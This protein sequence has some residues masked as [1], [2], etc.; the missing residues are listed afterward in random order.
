MANGRRATSAR[1]V[2]AL[3]AVETLCLLG[4]EISRFGMTIWIL[5]HNGEHS[6][7]AFSY[8]MAANVV[9]GML[10]L[11]IAGSVVDRQPRKAVMIGAAIVTAIGTALVFGGALVGELSLPVVLVGA[12]LASIGEAFQWPAL[13][14]TVPLLASAEDLPR[15]N[16][17]LESGRA[18]GHFA[19]PA[20]GGVS[21]A[22]LGVSGLVGIDLFAFVVST[23]VVATLRL[24]S[25][26]AGEE[27]APAGD[28]DEEG[29]HGEAGG[30]EGGDED[31]ESDSLIADAQVGLRWIFAR[32]PV[33]KL[34][35]V[36]TFA[37]FFLAVGE[38]VMQP[39]GLSLVGERELGI[40]NA[41]FGAGMIVGGLLCGPLAKRFTNIN[42]L[43]ASA[44]VLGV[45]YVAYGFARGPVGLAGLNVA[46]AMMI[47]IVN[48][49]LMTIWQLKVPERL[50]GRVFAA[51][52]LIADITTP[53]SFLLAGPISE[54]L[55]PAAYTRLGADAIWGA[56]PAGQ[57]GALCTVLGASLV[58]GFALAWTVRDI[59][60]IE[61]P[62][63][64]SSKP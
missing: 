28:N 10:V 22:V 48:S 55:L 32:R 49:S 45:A 18:I 6:V 23:I 36:A 2:W 19:G 27:E 54:Q 53:I 5:A 62:D 35:L 64:T 30:D 17:V 25:G 11:P 21:I 42:M 24:P 37:N 46:I 34:L 26:P 15:Y 39:Y 43:F 51:M 50:Q 52:G 38:V 33:V 31:D 12:G 16:G 56:S 58:A 8:L 7:S 41:C 14:A 47:T 44:L 40:V 63:R 13:A 60:D 3:I 29:D 20:I 59:R 61:E 1:T 57:L 4:A 9:P